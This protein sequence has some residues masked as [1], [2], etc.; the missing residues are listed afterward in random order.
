MLKN[1][2]LSADERLIQQARDKASNERKTLNSV[3]RG[4]LNRY[5][6]GYSSSLNYKEI[7]KK[8]SYAEPGRNFSREEL[9]ER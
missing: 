7:M 1:I 4:W 5:V 3:F 9:S 6:G 8:L 2:T